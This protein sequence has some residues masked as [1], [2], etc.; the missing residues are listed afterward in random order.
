LSKLPVLRGKEIVNL[1]KKAG[2]VMERQRG[3]HVFLK[4][5][6]KRA[7]VV[8]IHAGE[9]IGFLAHRRNI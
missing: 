4:H 9:T 3:S 1:P 5:S 6:D 7:A 8:L 2:F